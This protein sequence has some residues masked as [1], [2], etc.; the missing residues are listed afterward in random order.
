MRQK[1]VSFLFFAIFFRW[2]ELPE[3]LFEKFDVR[4][5]G[6]S[7]GWLGG[8]LGPVGPRPSGQRLRRCSSTA[9]CA[10]S[11]EPLGFA[12][13]QQNQFAAFRDYDD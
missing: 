13:S 6:S 12:S 11:V 1:G 3:E 2:L 9:R 4:G 7:G 5:S 8:L 10:V